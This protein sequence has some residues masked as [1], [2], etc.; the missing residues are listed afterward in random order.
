MAEPNPARRPS[1]RPCASHRVR[2]D[3]RGAKQD[4]FRLRKTEEHREGNDVPR[5]QQSVSGEAPKMTLERELSEA[6]S[7]PLW[8]RLAAGLYDLFPL[9]ALWFV[10]AAM[11]VALNRGQAV[12]GSGRGWLFSG[13]LLVTLLY[14]GMSYARGGQ[15]LGMRA[16]QIRLVD[17]RKG[18]LRPGRAYL[19]AI[20][21]LVQL[22]LFGLG[23]WWAL[24][25]RDRQ[26]LADRLCRTR[27][28]K[29]GP[30]RSEHQAGERP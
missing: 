17:E 15:T 27:L 11:A 21:G 28:I 14:F 12:V 4:T 23:L 1:P 5:E 10:L 3:A 29:I 26:S 13:L 18:S 25:D 20:A 8:R 30:R 2:G 19:R 16:W 6:V 9:S 7:A 24:C 22:L